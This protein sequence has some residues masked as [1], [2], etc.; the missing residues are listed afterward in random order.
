[1]TTIETGK[2]YPLWNRLHRFVMKR[3]IPYHDAEDLVSASLMSAIDKYDIANGQFDTFCFSILYNRMK[4]YWRDKK[5]TVPDG[6][7]NLPHHGSSALDNLIDEEE[8]MILK[9]ELDKHLKDLTEKER[10]FV[11][12]L[13]EVLEELGD[14][15]VS[16]AARRVGIMPSEGHN[17]LAKIRRRSTQVPI[18]P[19]VQR[20]MVLSE[21][22]QLS[23]GAYSASRKKLSDSPTAG[24]SAILAAASRWSCI[25]R[26]FAGLSESQH[27]KLFRILDGN[28]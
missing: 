8:M 13:G 21:D 2:F 19:L 5:Q 18:Q 23:Y 16:E 11:I 25:D 9:S 20:Q 7:D 12:V 6:I 4:N 1:M 14:R 28:E 26:F 3:G 27:A 17:I 22:R 15:G 10:N 24:L